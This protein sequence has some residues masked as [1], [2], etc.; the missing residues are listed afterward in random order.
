MEFRVFK[1]IYTTKNESCHCEFC[2]EKYKLY[3]TFL[4]YVRN[5]SR[6]Y[7]RLKLRFHILL[8]ELHVLP[9]LE[10]IAI[11]SWFYPCI[12]TLRALLHDT[13][14]AIT[15]NRK[16]SFPRPLKCVYDIESTPSV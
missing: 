1:F 13:V 7:A 11:H 10:E 8:L 2:A 3:Y 16:L 5:E 14:V 4:L 15:A 9:K 12:F 6:K